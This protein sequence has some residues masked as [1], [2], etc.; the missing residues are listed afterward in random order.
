[1]VDVEGVVASEVEIE[2]ATMEEE[3]E[4]YRR[5]RKVYLTVST[6]LQ[7]HATNYSTLPHLTSKFQQPD[8]TNFRCVHFTFLFE[9]L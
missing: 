8:F 3:E 1:M 4:M 6:I 9:L 5:T 2:E 7:M